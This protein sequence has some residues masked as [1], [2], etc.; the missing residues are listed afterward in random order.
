MKART[1]VLVLCGMLS[2]AAAGSTARAGIDIDFGASV[3]L[4]DDTDLYFAISSRYFDRERTVVESW[5]ARFRDP[6]DL[7]VALFISRHSGKSLDVI[8]DSRRKN[9]SWWDISVRLGVPVDVWFVPV[10]RDPGPPYGK[11]YGH[12]KKHRNDPA[13]VR[14]T[15]ADVGNLVA[16]RMI[17]EY[18]GV[19][20]EVAMEWRS[21]G[22][23][24][25][26]LMSGEYGKRRGKHRAAHGNPGKRKPKHKHEH[27]DRGR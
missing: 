15:D 18:Y 19:P 1:L 5:G 2:V 20:V 13:A 8:L 26:T 21:S 24:L 12:W 14:L 10:K 16:V 17:H 9:K 4:G 3:Q 7:A 27:E 22:S 25:R 23:D 6:D 11:A